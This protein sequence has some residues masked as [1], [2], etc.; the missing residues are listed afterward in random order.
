MALTP[1]FKELWSGF[2]FFGAFRHLSGLKSHFVI[3][4]K[5]RNDAWYYRRILSWKTTFVDSRFTGFNLFMIIF[6]GFFFFIKLS[7]LNVARYLI[8]CCSL[9][10]N[11][12][13]GSSA[14]LHERAR[15]REFFRFSFVK[16]KNKSWDFRPIFTEKPI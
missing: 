7:W 2:D 10:S 6:K 1:L 8:K 11:L 5:N 9:P 16:R 14:A 4:Q 12:P 15:Q 3:G 13:S